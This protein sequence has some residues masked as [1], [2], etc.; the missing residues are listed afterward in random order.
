M[1]PEILA[2]QLSFLKWFGALVVLAGIFFGGWNMVIQGKIKSL[3][4][5]WEWKDE[6]VKE[7]AENR[8]KDAKEYAT[9]GE[10]VSAVRDVRKDISNLSE[11]MDK[12][13]LQRG[14]NG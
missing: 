2:Q 9:R 12:V 5:L 3:T 7:C 4:K 13:L 6:F 1:T 11:K 10:L 14:E 8:L